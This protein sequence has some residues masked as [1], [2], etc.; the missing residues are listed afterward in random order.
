MKL[1]K[2][3][4]APLAFTFLVVAGSPADAHHSL[5]HDSDERA[6]LV[7]KILPATVGVSTMT[8][9]KGP[10]GSFKQQPKQ[11]GAAPNPFQDFLDKFN[12]G[13]KDNKPNLRPGGA[14][15]GYVV[16]K[17]ECIIYTNNHVAGDADAL[18]VRFEDGTVRNA[19]LIGRDDKV[20]VA[21]IKTDCDTPL[22]H[23]VELGDSD[24]ME[25]GETVIAIG[26]PLGLGTT[27]TM[28][29]VSAT[30]RNIGSGPYD[31]Y[32]QTDASINAGNSGGALFNLAGEVIG[33]N[34]AII[35]GGGGG[36]QGGQAGG[37]IGIGFAIPSNLVKAV[38][39]KIQSAKDGKVHRGWFG[40]QIG[41]VTDNMLDKLGMDS[42][43]GAII[44]GVIPDGPAA[45]AGLK[46]GDVILKFDGKTVDTARDLPRIVAMANAGDKVDVTVWRD[47]AEVTINVTIGDYDKAQAPKPSGRR[48]FVPNGPK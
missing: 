13:N 9:A 34:T 48:G 31:N 25:V 29:I 39:D 3:L 2:A 40:V 4:A 26:Q 28:G 23:Q 1:A 14:G 6:E 44:A 11:P 10:A 5:K 27:V 24:A 17:Q 8:K 43:H 19:T 30:G 41:A 35:S 32:L 47:N 20:D 21:V 22:S 42:A 18:K 12:E 36:Q 15:S 46:Q 7:K 33:M 38:A 16:D 45:D 37:S